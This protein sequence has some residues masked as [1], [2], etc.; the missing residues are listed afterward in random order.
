MSYYDIFSSAGQPEAYFA[1]VLQKVQAERIQDAAKI[2]NRD[3]VYRFFFFRSAL[4]FSFFF[5]NAV[6]DIP[7]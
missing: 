5:F 6:F 2:V 1:G 4:R 3:T 7:P